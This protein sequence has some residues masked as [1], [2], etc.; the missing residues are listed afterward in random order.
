[1][2]G[3]GFCNEQQNWRYKRGMEKEW[4]SN[5]LFAYWLRIFDLLPFFY[6]TTLFVDLS[7]LFPRWKSYKLKRGWYLRLR[8][9]R[10]WS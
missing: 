1:M 7:L 10:F 2:N 3:E 6:V 9:K 8:I 4:C 5:V